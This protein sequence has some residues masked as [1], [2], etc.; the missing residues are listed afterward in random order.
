MLGRL[1]TK[2]VMIL[3]SLI[4][5]TG[6]V[7]GIVLASCDGNYC[8]P[9]IANCSPSVYRGYNE[10]CCE[11]LDGDGIYHCTDC[12]YDL[13][14]CGGLLTV[15]PAYGCIYNGGPQCS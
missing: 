9:S 4:P 8:N 2:I 15:G 3:F 12:N 7:S 13:Y 1:R 14:W 6:F 5:V 10:Y 11:D